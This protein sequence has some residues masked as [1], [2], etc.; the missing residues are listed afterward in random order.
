M[1]GNKDEAIRCIKLSEKRLAN[2]D[3][4]GAL[5][6]A[7]KSYSLFETPEAEKLIKRIEDLLSTKPET[8]TSSSAETPSANSTRKRTQE[9]AKPAPS[10]GRT[11][12]EKQVLLV[13]RI[14][15]L[16]NHQ[17]YEILDIEKT[18][19]DSDIKKAYKK[20]ALQLHP[21]KN[22][23]PNADEAFKKVS[24]AFQILSD[25]NLRAD[26]D[27]TGRD[28]ESRSYPSASSG[29]SASQA[30]AGPGMYAEMSPED[31]FNAFFGNSM[32]SDSGPFFSFGSMGGPR[33]R[34]HR[35]GGG[36]PAGARRAQPG[37]Q[38]RGSSFVQVLVIAIMIIFAIVTNLLRDDGSTRLPSFSYQPYEPYTQARYMPQYRQPYYLRPTDIKRYSKRELSRMDREVERQFVHQLRMK[39]D[40]ESDVRREAIRRSYGWFSTDKEALARARA[41]P[42][43]SCQMLNDLNIPY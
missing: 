14:T 1:E 22:H 8:A 39:C 40:H 6:F 23:A 38:E 43:D 4:N 28:P 29:F 9:S 10:S 31:L 18:A 5:K 16:K 13:Q 36:R 3:F 19:T 11:Y 24:K 20:L 30:R 33:V 15:R 7:R 41:M 32:F 2:N 42:R 34:M 25:A 17:Y 26:Y 12:T 21:D 35:F 27:R 37:Q